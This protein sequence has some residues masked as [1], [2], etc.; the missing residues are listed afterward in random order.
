MVQGTDELPRLEGHDL[1]LDLETTSGDPKKKSV[2]PWRDC[3]IAGACVTSDDEKGSWYVPVRGPGGDLIEE[4]A[5]TMWLQDVVDGHERWVN[6]NV[7]YDAH[8]AANEGVDVG[9]IEMVDTLTLAKVIDADRGMKGGYGLSALSRDMLDR[10]ISRYE[11]SLKTWLA[12]AKSRDYGD[13]PLDMIGE[14]GCEDVITNRLLHAHLDRGCPDR[15]RGVWDTEVQLTPVLFDMERA[16][17]AVDPVELRKTQ[18]RTMA[19]MLKLEEL[20]HDAVGFP[21][22]PHT[23]ADCFELLCNKHGLPIVA[24]TDEGNPSFDKHA[25]N[26]YSMHP[27]VATDPELSDVVGKLIEYRK[28]HTAL[29][30]FIEPYS[31]LNVDGVLHP[32]YNQAVRTG[33]MSCSQPNAQQLNTFA[34]SMVHPR[35][36]YVLL[37][38]D[39]SQVEFRIIVH[40]LRN[41]RAM[42]AFAEDP[43]TDFHTWVADMCGVAREPAKNINFAMAFGGGKKRVLSMLSSD[44][45]LMGDLMG[46]AGGDA[47]L[48]DQLRNRRAVEVWEEYHGL[49]PELRVMSRRAA[50]LVKSRGHVFNAYGRRRQLPDSAAFRG[51]NTVVQGSAADL[52]KER[53]VA[54]SPRHSAELRDLGVRQIASVHDETLFEC[55]TESADAAVPIIAEL[56]ES[57]SV[58][59][60]VP[61]K[62]TVGISDRDWSRAGADDH[63]V[64]PHPAA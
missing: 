26:Q 56:M 3:R 48:F 36:G 28:L 44:M 9:S 30:F 61:I 4:G 13:L 7:K 21:I 64:Y 20:L 55:P 11:G 34:K 17:M 12:D 35:P 62:V 33:R 1:Y 60:R 14:Y 47:A 53:T 29:T 39:Y 57:P 43:W 52:M 27:I 41:E 38:A 23:S 42:R 15:S 46:R 5:F 19:K 37:S 8:C 49:L 50:M 58:E 24:W 59:F 63:V 54:T 51:F 32:T 40:Y 6:H 45:S 2:N 31:E 16:G 10:D 25:L 22:R 18:L